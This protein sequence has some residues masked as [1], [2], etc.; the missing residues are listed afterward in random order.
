M[1]RGTTRSPV[2]KLHQA[3]I[4]DFKAFFCRMSRGTTR[5]PVKKLHQARIND[6]KAFLCPD[7][8]GHPG[9]S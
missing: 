5:S 9:P 3:R 7:E 1:S 2:K 8:L 6:F 4:T